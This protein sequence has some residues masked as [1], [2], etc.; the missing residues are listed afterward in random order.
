MLRWTTLFLLPLLVSCQRSTA[1]LVI[2][3]RQVFVLGE[4]MDDGYRATLSNKGEQAVTVRLIDKK[5]R[6][7]NEQLTL[8]SGT[9]QSV[10][11]TADQE[12]RLYNDDDRKA[13]LLVEMSR[14]VEG[15]RYEGMDGRPSD[16]LA[17]DPPASEE[18][19]I[20]VRTDVGPPLTKVEREILPGNQLIIGEGSSLGYTASINT[21]GHLI[22]VSG[23]DKRSGR[24]LQGFGLEGKERV[25]IRPYEDLYL[26][27]TGQEAVRVRLTFDRPVRGARL[28]ET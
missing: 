21:L 24:Q 22:E 23:R 14:G 7:T 16:R 28:T 11:V 8:A 2:P 25:T 26:I 3:P 13:R 9:Q 15:M 10:S 20:V 19:A 4:Y 17:A 12:V 18:E 1:D 27:N 6:E 5:T